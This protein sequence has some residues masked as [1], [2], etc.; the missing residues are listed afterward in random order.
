MKA[1]IITQAGRYQPGR[2]ALGAIY[3]ICNNLRG[4]VRVGREGGGAAERV[5]YLPLRLSAPP[6]PCASVDRH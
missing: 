6:F 5:V 1:E 2:G 4:E 3:Q